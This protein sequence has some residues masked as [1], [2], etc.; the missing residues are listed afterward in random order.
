MLLL[1]VSAAITHPLLSGQRIA[2]RITTAR[3]STRS[4]GS[5]ASFLSLKRPILSFTEVI[6]KSKFIVFAGRA[7]S[8]AEAF[9]FIAT[10]RDDK[11]T[12]NCWAF[13]LSPNVYR[14]SD[15]GEP[16]GTAGKPILT[17]IDAS[18]LNEV[19][20]MVTRHFGGIKLGTGGLIRAYQGSARNALQV[21]L[22][23]PDAYL[24]RFSP[25]V[26]LVVSVPMRSA[27][28][29]YRFAQ[30]YGG[31]VSEYEGDSLTEGHEIGGADDDD[32]ALSLASFTCTIPAE[33][34]AAF[35]LSMQNAC[36]GQATFHDLAIDS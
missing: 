13:R 19:V 7:R 9:S 8:E 28:L 2:H 3:M 14:F 36:K 21:T 26:C 24:S 31:S 18:K 32:A 33:H 4:A 10:H 15:D 30:Q 16:A 35:Q 29:P 34:A 20:V 23:D 27:S 12:H 22:D 6:N 11:A 25:T 5:D 17:A 1:S